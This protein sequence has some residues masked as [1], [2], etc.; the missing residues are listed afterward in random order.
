MARNTVN[1]T[2]SIE[3][4]DALFL[5]WAS[6]INASDSSA[7]HWPSR[8][9]IETSTATSSILIE[10]ALTDTNRDLDDLLDQTSSIEDLNALLES[11][12]PT[13]SSQTPHERSTFRFGERCTGN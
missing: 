3:P 4:P 1:T 13:T 6:G 11:D 2:V 7:K 9:P 5:S 10:E 12:P 8:W